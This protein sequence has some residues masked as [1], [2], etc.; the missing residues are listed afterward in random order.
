MYVYIIAYLNKCILEY[1]HTIVKPKETDSCGR[2]IRNEHMS[3]T[4][5]ILI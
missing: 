2:S 1:M 5:T 3:N 4:N